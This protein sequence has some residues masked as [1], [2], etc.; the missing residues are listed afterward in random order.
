MAT[1]IPQG[2]MKVPSVFLQAEEV[3][4]VNLFVFMPLNGKL[5]HY[6]K[7][8][9]VLPTAKLMEIMKFSGTL[10]IMPESEAKEGM[11][12]ISGELTEGIASPGAISDETSAKAVGMIKSLGGSPDDDIKARA[13]TTKS[14][15]DNS[16]TVAQQLID[17]FKTGDIKGGVSKLLLDIKKE[18]SS[19]EGHE[20]HVAALGVL[21]FLALHDGTSVDATDIA[22]AGFVH[23]IG[24]R[25]QGEAEIQRHVGGEELRSIIDP[26]FK[27]PETRI[28]KN[29]HI[30]GGV[31][32]LKGLGVAI[33]DGAMKIVAQHHENFDG[34][35]PW[36]L[37][38]GQIYKPA[39]VFRIV[40]D[41]VCLL[42][43]NWKDFDLPEAYA[44]LS[45]INTVNGKPKYYDPTI[46]TQIQKIIT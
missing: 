9:E 32:S 29:L 14:S 6:L 13:T 34:S 37:K 5:V 8:G 20:K 1:L 11:E 27:A 4:K 21:A 15:L 3:M 2:Y 10:L 7:K 18:K 46:M 31:N 25:D 30:E 38:E 42:N 44:T 41:L 28:P 26:T 43:C 35:G 23:D 22:V 12:A 33:A 16:A 17:K 40:D 24:M 36:G 39:R 19:L 45:K